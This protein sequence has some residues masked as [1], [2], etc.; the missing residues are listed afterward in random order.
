MVVL[1]VAARPVTFDDI[2]NAQLSGSIGAP[3]WCEE[4]A[5]SGNFGSRFSRGRSALW[6]SFEGP[7][8]IRL[9]LTVPRGALFRFRPRRIA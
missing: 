6:N 5:A 3:G 9:H 1:R 2:G 4:R 8:N 7:Y